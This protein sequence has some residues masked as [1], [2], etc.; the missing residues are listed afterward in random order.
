MTESKMRDCL[1]AAGVKNLKDFGYPFANAKNI[2]TNKIYAAFFKSM[3]ESDEN[4]TSNT[5]LEKV[6]ITLLNE[7]EP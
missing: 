4:I 5:T 2:L 3:L 1:I 7:L 6:R